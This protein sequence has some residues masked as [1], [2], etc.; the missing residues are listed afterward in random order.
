MWQKINAQHTQMYMEN[1]EKRPSFWVLWSTLNLFALVFKVRHFLFWSEPFPF[2]L[3]YTSHYYARFRQFTPCPLKWDGTGM[4]QIHLHVWGKSSELYRTR[5][6]RFFLVFFISI[7]W[8][9]YHLTHLVS[10]V[11]DEIPVV[12]QMSVSDCISF[13]FTLALH[14]LLTAV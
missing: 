3:L 11:S 1:V 4:R 5:R 12:F 14:L 13:V 6:S 10:M 7:F 2:T 8:T 9:T